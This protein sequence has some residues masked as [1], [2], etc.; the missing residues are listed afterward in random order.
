MDR[1]SIN[2]VS[3]FRWNFLEDIA[4]YST[5]GFGGIGVWRHKVSD[6]CDHTVGDAIRAS[7]L[8][9]SSLQWVGGFTGSDGLSFA[10]AI[11]DAVTAIR[12]ASIMQAECLI[13]HPGSTNGHTH[14]HAI[15]LFNAALSELVPV[16]Q[17][18]GVRLALEP[19]HSASGGKFTFV[20]QIR[21]GLDLIERFPAKS[22]GIVLDLYYFGCQL[23]TLADLTANMDRLALVQLADRRCVS[24]CEPN[25]CLPGRGTIALGEWFQALEQADYRGFYEF[26]LF[27]DDIASMDA[28]Q[29]LDSLAKYVPAMLDSTLAAKSTASS[30]DDSP[31]NLSRLDHV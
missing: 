10:E 30:S 5:L 27:G 11:E 14:R 28:F 9:V 22:L 12:S 6:F 26:E 2:E 13:V 24:N 16:A 15:R 4:R 17:D 8:K 29:L 1:I 25:R 18:F 23:A 7:R 20:D 31:A 21:S 3:T 19:M